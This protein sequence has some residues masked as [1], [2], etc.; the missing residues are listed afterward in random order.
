MIRA[1]PRPQT[2]EGLIIVVPIPPPHEAE[3][4]MTAGG[5]LGPVL[6]MATSAGVHQWSVIS[7]WGSVAHPEKR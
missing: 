6:R 7:G 2:G 3:L 5:T 4:G 1:P